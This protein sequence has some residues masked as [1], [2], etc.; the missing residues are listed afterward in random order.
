MPEK[1]DLSEYTPLGLADGEVDLSNSIVTSTTSVEPF[2]ISE[3]LVG[4][5][6]SMG[7]SENGC[8][9][10]AI[11][12]NNGDVETAMGWVLEHMDDADFNDA[13]SLPTASETAPV[14]SAID[15]DQIMLLSSMGFTTEQATA[16]LMATN[17][18]VER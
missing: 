12:T 4:Q 6:V 5:L 10:A 7:F 2:V 3:D 9:R 1:L 15:E 16:A 18:N 17:S 13:P 11:A 14:T 8:R